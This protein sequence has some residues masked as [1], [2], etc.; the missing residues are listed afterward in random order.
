MNESMP[1]GNLLVDD[2]TLD[3]SCPFAALRMNT[4]DG[5]AAAAIRV[6][7]THE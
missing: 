2:A 3:I 7:Q 5:L 4:F 1:V 6:T